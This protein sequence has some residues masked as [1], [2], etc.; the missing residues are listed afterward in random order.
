VQVQ[1]PFPDATDRER[2]WRVHLPA[3]LP[4]EGELD[5]A[6]LAQRY[7]LSGGYI[8]NAALRAAY[9]AAGEGRALSA[10][11]LRRAVVLEYQRAG[12]IGDGR[13]E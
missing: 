6:K 1:F 7:Q 12:Q 10:D 13:L 8:R 5:V 4:I 3:S 9:L 2:L 11:H